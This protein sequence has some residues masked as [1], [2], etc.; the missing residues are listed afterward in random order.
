MSVRELA[1]G[2][3][4]SMP[5]YFIRIR[6]HKVNTCNWHMGPVLM[7]PLAFFFSK[8][9][10]CL[11]VRYY[12]Y[13][14]QVTTYCARLPALQPSWIKRGV[15]VNDSILDDKIS[16]DWFSVIKDVSNPNPDPNPNPIPTLIVILKR[17]LA[18]ALALALALPL[19]LTR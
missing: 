9:L 4:G 16:N 1:G 14:N 17:I 7:R 13:R 3:G 10:S 8:F 6:F 19:T 18:L 5:I 12:R 2:R 11:S 15:S